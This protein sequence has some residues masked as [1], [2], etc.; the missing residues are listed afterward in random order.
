MTRTWPPIAVFGAGAVGTYF[1]GMLARAGAPVTLVGR[2]E[3]VQAIRE[4]GLR[5]DSREFHATVRA[6]ASSDPAAVGGARIL[7]LCVKATDPETAG[8]AFAPHLDPACVV[9]CLQNGV[10]NA[11]RLG[12]IVPNPAVPA[13]VYVSAEMIGPGRVRHNGRGDLILGPSPRR[14]AAVDLDLL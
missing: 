11:E 5:I 6:D 14:T 13:V 9:V 10:D 12:A 8:G 1:G 4:H 2:P 7:L 3:H